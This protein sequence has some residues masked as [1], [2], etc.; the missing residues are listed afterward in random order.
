MNYAK[1][2]SASK[3]PPPLFAG[4]ASPEDAGLH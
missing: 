2:E 4:T 3:T 1:N